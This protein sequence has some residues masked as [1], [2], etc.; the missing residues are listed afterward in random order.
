M[1]GQKG[2]EGNRS[3]QQKALTQSPEGREGRQSPKHKVANNTGARI[4]RARTHTYQ[5]TRT[6][7]HTH[8][9]L[10]PGTQ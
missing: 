7:A 1:S 6:H 8:S 2:S 10:P 5:H 4:K 3:T 9:F